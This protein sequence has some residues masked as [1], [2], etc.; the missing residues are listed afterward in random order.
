MVVPASQV[1]LLPRESH[2]VAS[3]F[4][5]STSSLLRTEQKERYDQADANSVSFEKLSISPP[6]RKT[7]Q[8][9]GRYRDRSPGSLDIDD[10][11]SLND[12]RPT[13]EANGEGGPILNRRYEYMPESMVP[14]WYNKSPKINSQG[15]GGYFV[16][17][18]LTY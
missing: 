10:G 1:D 16:R 9:A 14:I 17:N 15:S 12:E 11:Q 18:M 13:D 4:R 2:L 8:S 5:G 7:S 3:D 6:S